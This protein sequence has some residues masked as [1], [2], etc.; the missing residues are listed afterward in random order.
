[1]AMPLEILGRA[2][3]EMG[4]TKDYFYVMRK[5]SPEKFEVIKAF[6]EDFIIAVNKYN[7]FVD[8]LFMYIHDWLL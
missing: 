4:L 8:D 3:I 1:M 6:D 2:A 7:S 5:M